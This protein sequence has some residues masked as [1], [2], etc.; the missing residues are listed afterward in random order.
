MFQCYNSQYLGK[1]EIF[2]CLPEQ[3]REASK[4]LRSFS[5]FTLEIY[6]SF[7]LH[8]Q[9]KSI[10]WNYSRYTQLLLEF[11]SHQAFLSLSLLLQ[12]Q[13]LSSCCHF[14]FSPVHSTPVELQW[15]PPSIA[16]AVSRALACLCSLCTSHLYPCSSSAKKKFS[17]VAFIYLGELVSNSRQFWHSSTAVTAFWTLEHQLICSFGFEISDQS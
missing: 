10:K 2:G 7:H 14:L 3:A 12:A 9:H 4:L 5:C 13:S 11:K 6:R 15:H 16:A 1:D 17:G 8:V